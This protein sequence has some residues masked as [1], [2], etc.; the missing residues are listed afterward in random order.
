MHPKFV[1]VDRQ[2]GFMPSC[3][4]SWENWFECCITLKGP[5]VDGLIEFW[6]HFWGRKET[7]APFHHSTSHI[8]DTLNQSSSTLDTILLPSPHH[9]SLSLSIP[10][11]IPTV[12]P[13]RPPP[14]PLNTF[15]LS[16]VKAAKYSI[17]I[18]SPNLTC[19]AIIIALQAA[20]ARC[21]DVTIITNRRMMLLEQIVTA[22]TTTEYEIWKLK[23]AYCRLLRRRSRTVHAGN[24]EDAAMMEEG[25]Q[26]EVLGKLKICYFRAGSSAGDNEPMRSHVKCTIVDDEVAVLGSG[27]MDRAS[28]YTSQELG[29]ACFGTDTVRSI[30]EILLKGL[31][32]RLEEYFG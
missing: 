10:P 6:S 8:P 13:R 29:I 2:K 11:L 22:A 30:G 31:E 23:R 12:T 16:I 24:D 1:I 27:N 20:L 32:G 17:K 21:V 15:L 7:L 5:V 9:S 26:H 14:T 4:L 18:I 28:W 3:N 19:Q 25:Q